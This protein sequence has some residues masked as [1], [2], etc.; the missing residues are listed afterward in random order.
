MRNRPVAEAI[1]FTLAVLLYIWILRF[2]WPSTV[3]LL[4]AAVLASCLQHSET[5]RSVG[6]APREIRSS[7]AEWKAGLL[8]AALA[9]ALLGGRRVFT[10]PMLYRGLLYFLWCVAQQFVYQAMI[11]RRFRLAFGPS[12]RAASLS[13]VLFS[14]V[15]LPNPVLAPAT[16]LWGALSSRLFERRPSVPVLG[17]LQFLLSSILLWLTPIAWHRNF[18]VGASYLHFR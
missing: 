3:W 6:L 18:R 13:G 5:I 2:R 17:L 16:L 12:W 8:L 9:T 10:A 7:L 14:L 15:H 1:A 4:V 11:C